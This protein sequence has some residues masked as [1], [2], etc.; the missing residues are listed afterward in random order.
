MW[1]KALAAEDNRQP[2]LRGKTC[3]AAKGRLKEHESGVT[4]VCAHQ[5]Y[6][7]WLR[8]QWRI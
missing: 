8:E 3:R 6:K 5:E 2:L 1:R 4:S 7:K